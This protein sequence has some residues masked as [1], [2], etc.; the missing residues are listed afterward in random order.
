MSTVRSSEAERESLGGPSSGRIGFEQTV[1][2]AGQRSFD[3]RTQT[4]FR[5]RSLGDGALAGGRR[6]FERERAPVD[7][8]TWERRIQVE[9]RCETGMIG[10]RKAS[11]AVA[12]VSGRRVRSRTRTK[13]RGQALESAPSSIGVAAISID[14]RSRDP[15][16][17]GPL[18]DCRRRHRG[19]IARDRGLSPQKGRRLSRPVPRRAW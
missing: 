3:S 4:L 17:P 19:A 5:L 14:H 7:G 11:V 12:S 15:R 8:P 10:P 9:P 16:D 1:L 18:R 6:E 13:Y 2:A